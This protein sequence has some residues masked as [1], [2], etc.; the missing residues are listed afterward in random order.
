MGKLEGKVAIV[1]AGGSGIGK[2][3]ARGLA[4]EGTKVVIAGR[5]L[6]ALNSAV[7]EFSKIRLYRCRDSH[8]RQQ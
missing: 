5:R 3:I 7:E 6:K 4:A 2:G 1:T 8:G